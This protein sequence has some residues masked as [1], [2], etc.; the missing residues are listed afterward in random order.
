MGGGEKGW[1]GHFTMAVGQGLLCAPALP[2][3]NGS[4]YCVLAPNPMSGLL[5]GGVGLLSYFLG[6]P[7]KGSTS[8]PTTE[9]LLPC[10]QMLLPC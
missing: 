4:V 1:R 5:A 8:T 9:M 2:F 6:A 3:P 10:P 7:N